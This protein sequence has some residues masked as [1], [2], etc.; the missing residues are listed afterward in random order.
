MNQG[1]KSGN[2]VMVFICI[3][4]KEFSVIKSP[5]NF[6]LARINLESRTKSMTIK[7]VRNVEGN[8]QAMEG[9]KLLNMTVDLYQSIIATI[10]DNVE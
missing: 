4:F 2:F 1:A 6:D 10:E 3:F 9:L 8:A 7:R 5:A